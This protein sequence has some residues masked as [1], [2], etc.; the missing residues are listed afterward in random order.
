MDKTIRL[1]PKCG[2]MD[3]YANCPACGYRKG[4][5]RTFHNK[6]CKCKQCKIKHRQNKH[7]R[8]LHGK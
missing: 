5:K 1:C 8:K 3:N 4:K 7:I 6:M 2:L